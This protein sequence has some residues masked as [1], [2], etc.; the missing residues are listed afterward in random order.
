MLGLLTGFIDELRAA[1]IPVSMVESIDAARGM[2]HVNLGSRDEL[3]GLLGSTLI[4]SDRH[5]P[6]FE[7]TFEAYFALRG[8]DPGSDDDAQRAA[9]AA[10]LILGAGGAAGDDGGGEASD[11]IS[12]LLRALREQNDAVMRAV[13]RAAV[14]R[15]AGI[16]PGRPVG[17]AYYLYRVMRQLS[18][19]EIEQKLIEET[20]AGAGLETRLAIEEIQRSIERFRQMVRTEIRQRLVAD[21]GA[22]AVT[23]TLRRPLIEDVDLTSATRDELVEIERLV[24]PLGRR[25]AT[26]LSQRRRRGR[27]GRLDV[28]ATMR[29]SLSTGGTP[30]DPRFRTPRSGKPEIVLLCD[31][32]GSVA[33]FARFTMQ[34]VY[35]ISSQFA[36]V[37]TFAFIDGIDEVTRMFGSGTDFGT[38]M[39]R[40]SREAE[41]VWLDGHSDYG[42]AFAAFTSRYLDEAVTPRTS[43]LVTGDARS[44]YHDPHVE[45]LAA[46]SERAKTLLWLNPE[47]RRYW[48]T[49]DSVMGLYEPCCDDVAEIRTLRQLSGFVE[50]V[51]LPRPARRRT[52]VG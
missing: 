5:R 44:N 2:E 10:E 7:A 8:P 29:T 36:R 47:P 6:T 30:I 19:D 32:S 48:D 42:H 13:M 33:T 35:A 11:L 41:V 3:R 43:V 25:L 40:I 21:R 12:A 15:L 50:Q 37:R 9:D 39:D 23:R 28:R 17:G 26:R 16:E 27:N 24:H 46:L 45:A 22:A 31:V 18:I 4:K 38:A 14:D 51:A 34:L 52:V 49:G 1:G 20:Q